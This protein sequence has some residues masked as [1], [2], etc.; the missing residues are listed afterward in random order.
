MEVTKFRSQL[1]I[2]LEQVVVH[3]CEVQNVFAKV[4]TIVDNRSRGLREAIR[5]TRN[6]LRN[7]LESILQAVVAPGRTIKKLRCQLSVA[8]QPVLAHL[9][10]AQRALGKLN[11]SVTDKPRTVQEAIRARES[12]LPRLLES[13]PDA[14]VAL[15][16]GLR[17]VAANPKALDLFGIS[18][19]NME[20][21]AIDAF[22]PVVKF[23]LRGTKKVRPS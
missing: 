17:F 6:D 4:S 22:L 19:R 13:S 10:V 15:N 18:E 8:L 14:I 11:T 23:F 21:F 7:W 3:V 1:L 9:R 12:D 5:A 2:A 16:T 20:M